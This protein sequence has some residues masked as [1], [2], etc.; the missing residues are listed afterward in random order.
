MIEAINLLFSQEFLIRA[1]VVGVL[2]LDAVT[3]GHKVHEQHGTYKT[4]SAEYSDRRKVLHSVITVL[5]E[6]IERYRI[7][8]CYGRHIERYAECIQTEEDTE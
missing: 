8:K 7:G 3:I 6:N 4:Y 5:F 2:I 1:L